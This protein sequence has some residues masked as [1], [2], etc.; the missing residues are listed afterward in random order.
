MPGLFIYILK[1]SI[2]LAVVYLFYHIVLR[3]LTFHSW[4]RWY[5]LGYSCFSF[6]VAFF[7][8]T[9]LF[10]NGLLYYGKTLQLVPAIDFYSRRITPINTARVISQSD[11]SSWDLSL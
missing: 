2:C 5:L 1:L 4:N 7:N 8:I 10:R 3:K 6:F 9:P 11:W